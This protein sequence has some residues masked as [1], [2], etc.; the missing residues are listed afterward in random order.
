M[1]NKGK[2]ARGVSIIGAAFTPFGNVLETP[3]IKG[4]TFRELLSWAALG[5][6]ES[7]GI[8]PKDVDSLLVAHYQ[9]EPVKTQS[10]HAVASEWLGMKKKPAVKYE[11][12][13]ASGASGVRLAGSLIASGID[14]IVLLVAVEILNSVIDEELEEYRKQP[15]ARIPIEPVDQFD[16]VSNGFDQAYFQPFAFDL[17]AGLSAFPI[18]A[19]A[20]K[21]NLTVDQIEEAQNAASISLRR[22]AARNPRAFHRKEF[23]EIAKEAGFADVMAYMKSSNNPYVSWPVRALHLYSIAD[24]AAAMVLCPSEDAKKYTDK[25]VDVLGVGVASGLTYYSDPLNLPTE[26]SAFEQAYKMADLNPKDIDYLGLHD[27]MIHQHITE[28]EMA[29][30]FEPGEA[31][32][33]IIEGR[34]AFDGD[35]PINTHGGTPSMGNTYDASGVTEIAEPVLQM[36]GEC[37]E[38]QI[39]PPPKVAVCHAL[40]SGPTF[41][42]T[43]LKGRE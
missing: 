27:C 25:P 41:G 3:E 43:V 42:V 24:G 26:M 34:T 29:G 16:F 39:D 20:K 17:L 5:A 21:Y 32:K 1:S 13:C 40:G 35:K 36:R 2:W 11:T 22:N 7:A 37:G 23:A 14:D 10:I 28:S 30:Y 33:A 8:T 12:A 9:T 38:R 15:A 4:M 6:L 31:W 19:Y 18:L